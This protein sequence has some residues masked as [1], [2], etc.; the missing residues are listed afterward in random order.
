MYD[1]GDL[2]VAIKHGAKKYLDWKVSADKL[3]LNIFL[4]VFMDG[5]REKTFPY[6]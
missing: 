3:D 6:R 5:I 2:P 1:R 4:P